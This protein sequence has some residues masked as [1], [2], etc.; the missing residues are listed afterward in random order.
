MGTSSDLTYDD[1]VAAAGRPRPS[2]P[3]VEPQLVLALECERPLAYG[4]RFSLGDTDEVLFGRGSK[5]SA[6]RTV[7]RGV[8]RL[9]VTVPDRRMS[10]KHGR[11]TRERDGYLYEDLRS[12]NG[13]RVDGVAFTRGRID[14]GHHLQLGHTFFFLREAMPTP[15]GTP[16]DV[17]WDALRTEPEGMRTLLPAFAQ[18][19]RALAKVARSTVSVLLEAETGTGKEVLARGVHAIST[20]GSRPLV[21][22]NCGALPEAL[23]ESQLFGH[24]KGAFSGAVRDE[25]GLVRSADHGTLFL[26][27]VGELGRSAQAALLRVLQEGEVV[28]VGGTRPIAVDFRLVAATHRRLDELVTRGEFRADLLARMS[29]L[30]F[31]IPALRQRREDIGS[32]VAELLTRCPPITTIEPAAALALLAHDWPFNTR[33]L[34]KVLGL[35]TVLADGG[36]LALAHLPPPVAASFEAVRAPKDDRNE[37]VDSNAVDDRPADAELR[38]TLTEHLTRS[39]GNVTEVARAMGKARQQIHRWLRRLKID[40]D[41]FRS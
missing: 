37:G 3:R 4:A 29:G 31:H 10:T 34:E 8:K 33:E 6:T 17:D 19:L 20:R 21:A 5:R 1:A 32:L 7:E 15:H 35:A 39:K 24:V 16:D 25:L 12:T 2:E 36:T 14:D 11:L 38:A 30:T 28:P 22:V 41:A 26:D 9:V 27:E 40:S 13:S 18:E 23:V